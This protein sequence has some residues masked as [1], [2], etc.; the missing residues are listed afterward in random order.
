[1]L[2]PLSGT[3]L[4]Y[5]FM[6]KI[7]SAIKKLR[8]DKKRT[9]ANS[10]FEKSV[11][12]AIKK[13]GRQRSQ[14]LINQAISLVDKAVKKHIFHK[15]KAARIKSRLSKLVAEVK[16]PKQRSAPK[17][18]MPKKRVPTTNKT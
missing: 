9:Q 2:V 17:R 4:P 6:P 16:R 1:M 13:A 18:S 7:K 12:D 3:V 14:Q 11:K 5:I 10:I 15:N 8:Q